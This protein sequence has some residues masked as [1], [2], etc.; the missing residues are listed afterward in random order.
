MDQGRSSQDTWVTFSGGREIV[1][2][3][4]Q[5]EDPFQSLVRDTVR[6]PLFP[7]PYTPDPTPLNPS[8]DTTSTLTQLNPLPKSK[9]LP[10][11]LPSPLRRALRGDTLFGGVGGDGD[12][13]P[14]GGGDKGVGGSGPTGSDG[15]AAAPDPF[16]WVGFAHEFPMRPAA[17]RPRLR[18]QR[19]TPQAPPAAA[20]GAVAA[21]VGGGATA[22]TA[23]RLLPGP[24]PT[25]GSPTRLLPPASHPISNPSS[26]MCASAGVGA[27]AGVN[28]GGK[29]P[30]LPFGLDRPASHPLSAQPSAWNS[31]VVDAPI[32]GPPCGPPG[33]S[34]GGSSACLT[35]I[36]AAVASRLAS[37]GGR[38]PLGLLPL[39][40][41]PLRGPGEGSSSFPSS[42]LGSGAAVRSPWT[43]PL[44]G[45]GCL[46]GADIWEEPEGEPAVNEESHD[47]LALVLQVGLFPFSWV[48]NLTI[49]LNARRLEAPNTTMFVFLVCFLGL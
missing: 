5:P 38:S 13:G 36:P 40:L 34:V 37:G 20:A 25:P 14:V 24:E 31:P 6:G 39:N 47:A 1:N 8:T 35:G 15:A 3:P 27:V 44:C 32:C 45:F 10:Q 48:P 42:P 23:P 46:E 28:N 21:T 16:A 11:D 41:P 29:M 49:G 26:P 18:A 17:A 43:S 12:D 9:G 33:A 30:V 19:P 22:R 7:D 4:T 2:S